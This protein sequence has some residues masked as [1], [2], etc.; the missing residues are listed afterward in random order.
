MAQKQM[1][2]L[3]LSSLSKFQN[4]IQLY[5]RTYSVTFK[6]NYKGNAG[7]VLAI[8]GSI[9]ELGKFKQFKIKMA[10]I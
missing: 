9:P 5:N 2:T 8:T 7:D 1:T 4:V 10:K 6:L 3:D